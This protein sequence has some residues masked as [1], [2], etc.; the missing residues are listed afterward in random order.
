ME[1]LLLLEKAFLLVN[2]RIPIFGWKDKNVF[3]VPWKLCMKAIGGGVLVG[4]G[5]R[6]ERSGDSKSKLVI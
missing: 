1:C 2:S 4:E 5:G 3:S 6:K